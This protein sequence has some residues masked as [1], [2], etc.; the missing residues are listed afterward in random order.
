MQFF[1]NYV[2]AYDFYKFDLLF[3]FVS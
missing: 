1:V 3:E 2:F